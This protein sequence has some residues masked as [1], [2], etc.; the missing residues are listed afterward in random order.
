M[1][2]FTLKPRNDYCLFALQGAY[3]TLELELQRPFAVEKA[4][5]DLLDIER[6]RQA[7]DPAASAD[8]AALLISASPFYLFYSVYFIVI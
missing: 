3:H 1:L 6:I 8:L 4:A 7:C 2:I 5:W